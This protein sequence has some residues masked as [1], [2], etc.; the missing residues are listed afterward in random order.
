MAC[1]GDNRLD[2]GMTIASV[3]AALYRLDT[4]SYECEFS[5]C[6]VRMLICTADVLRLSVIKTAICIALFADSVT[7]EIAY[8]ILVAEL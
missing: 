7:H 6:I 2:H 8:F 4:Q 1:Y 5:F 3:S